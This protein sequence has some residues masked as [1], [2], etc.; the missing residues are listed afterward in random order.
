[1]SAVTDESARHHHQP[2]V[3]TTNEEFMLEPVPRA[4][5]RPWWSMFFIWVGFGYVPTGL[6]VGGQLAG[7]AGGGRE[8]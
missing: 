4:A 5:R 7:E 2:E 6:I 8:P 3:D 1:M